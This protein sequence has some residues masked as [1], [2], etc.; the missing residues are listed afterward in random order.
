VNE[1][2]S[3]VGPLERYAQTPQCIH[4]CTYNARTTLAQSLLKTVTSKLG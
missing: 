4:R 3:G 1:S 2:K